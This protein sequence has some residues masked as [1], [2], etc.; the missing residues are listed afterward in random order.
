MAGMQCEGNVREALKDRRTDPVSVT[1]QNHVLNP[2]DQSDL[3][4]R[5]LP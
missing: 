1:A 3:K 2:T 4:I 5:A